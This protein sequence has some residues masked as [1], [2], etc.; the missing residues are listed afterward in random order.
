[1]ARMGSN[2]LIISK[3]DYTFFR[4]YKRTFVA[5]DEWFS[6]PATAELLIHARKYRQGAPYRGYGQTEGLNSGAAHQED[7][8]AKVSI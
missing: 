2:F 4:V 7:A 1:M 5:G 6:Q 3:L 8:A